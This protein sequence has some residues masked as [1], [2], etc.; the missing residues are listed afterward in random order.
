MLIF[1]IKIYKMINIFFENFYYKLSFAILL[2]VILAFANRIEVLQNGAIAFIILILFML[3]LLS[4]SFNE[5]YG[6]IL[7]LAAMFVLTYNNVTF[8]KNGNKQ[9]NS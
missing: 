8:K 3:M 7:L 5:D 9:I 6:I 1:K 2:C 4:G